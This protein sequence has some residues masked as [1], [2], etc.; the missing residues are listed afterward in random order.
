MEWKN[1][2]TFSC[3]HC[4]APLTD[5]G[6]EIRCTRCRFV[7]ERDRYENIKR[8]RTGPKPANFVPY[9]WQNVIDDCC[10]LC[11]SDLGPPQAGEIRACQRKGCRF[12]ISIERLLKIKGDPRHPAHRFHHEA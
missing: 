11:G 10:P 4:A 12:R 5:R 8:H 3:P 7:I 1:L 9:K 2:A 6:E